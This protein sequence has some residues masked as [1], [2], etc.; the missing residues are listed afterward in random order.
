MA[1]LKQPNKYMQARKILHTIGVP[2]PNYLAKT[3]YTLTKRCG[4]VW[5]KP[6]KTWLSLASMQLQA[7]ERGE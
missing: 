3:V 7:K 4:F 2:P 1:A 6:T 5:N